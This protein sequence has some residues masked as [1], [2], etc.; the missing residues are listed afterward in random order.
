MKLPT[1]SPERQREDVL[2]AAAPVGGHIVGWADDWEVSV[3]N[4]DQGATGGMTPTRVQGRPGRHWTTR[5]VE[6][7]STPPAA[8]P[9]QDDGAE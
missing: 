5:V 7:L 9:F 4:G 6:R 8:E 3:A 1:S 2:T